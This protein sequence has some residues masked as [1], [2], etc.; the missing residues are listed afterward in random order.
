MVTTVPLSLRREW[1]VLAKQPREVIYTEAAE[2]KR[3]SLWGGLLIL[4]ALVCLIGQTGTFPRMNVAFLP[5][6]LTLIGVFII[7]AMIAIG[8]Q[9][10]GLSEQRFFLQ[11]GIP[12]VGTVIRRSETGSEFA[13][14]Y[15]VIYA[16]ITQDRAAT[17]SLS[18]SKERYDELQMDTPLIVLVDPQDSYRF[19]PYDFLTDVALK[20]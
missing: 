15:Q 14:T 10:A 16:F 4:L 3:R 17:G 6:T 9:E 5:Y 12:C 18:V 2:R 11:S 1:D 20:P 8:A 13:P 7:V 19:I